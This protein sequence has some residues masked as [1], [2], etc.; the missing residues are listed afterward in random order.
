[1][2]IPLDLWGCYSFGMKIL[3]ALRGIGKEVAGLGLCCLQKW[4]QERLLLFCLTH[5]ALFEHSD[6]F[7]FPSGKPVCLITHQQ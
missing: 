1:M 3:P 6:I 5:I 7:S 2:D 4:S